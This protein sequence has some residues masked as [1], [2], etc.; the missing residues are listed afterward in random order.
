MHIL[1]TATGIGGEAQLDVAGVEGAPDHDGRV[2]AADIIWDHLNFFLFFF[3]G[4]APPLLSPPSLSISCSAVSSSVSSPSS[5]DSEEM[6]SKISCLSSLVSPGELI[7]GL[8]LSSVLEVLRQCDGFVAKV[9]N[10]IC[11]SQT[12]QY[13]LKEVGQIFAP[14]SL[15][16]SRDNISLFSGLHLSYHFRRFFSDRLWVGQSI[17]HRPR[18]IVHFCFTRSCAALWAADLDWIVGPEYSLGRNKQKRHPG[19]VTTDLGGG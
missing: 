13:L 7:L 18:L 19:G 9:D 2:G 8:L 10:C 16:T 3:F 6:A 11:F 17:C 12:S 1:A 4:G 14:H 5:E 15:T